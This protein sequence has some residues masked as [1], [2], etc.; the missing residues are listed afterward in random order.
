[1][2]AILGRSRKRV[3]GRGTRMFGTAVRAAASRASREVLRP[4]L[5]AR[6]PLPIRS[7]GLARTAIC[8]ERPARD[9][10]KCV[11]LDYVNSA[12]R[13]TRNRRGS[14]AELA[15]LPHG[16]ISNGANLNGA[17]MT[18][19][20]SKS[21]I[22][23]RSAG[24]TFLEVII[25]ASILSIAA[26]AVLELLASSD[27]I[28]LTARR[29]ALA[30]VEAERA[31]EMCAEAI[32]DGEALPSAASL[33]TGMQGEALGGCTVSIAATNVTEEFTIPPAGPTGSPRAVPIRLRFLVATVEAPNG[34]VLVRLERAVPV[35]NF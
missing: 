32:K 15:R 20:A 30:A 24:L 1:M 7:E 21:T 23:R 6:T 33:Q 18:N 5:T 16:G 28:G 3:A 19:D 26:I 12:E 2:V 25:A 13:P 9:C 17:S 10:V 34:E 31:L 29:Q 4:A 14:R 22:R 35:E 27:S 11:D 8:A